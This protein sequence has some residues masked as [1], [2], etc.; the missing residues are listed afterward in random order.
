MIIEIIQTI[1]SLLQKPPLEHPNLGL[2]IM[3]KV[4]IIVRI[5]QRNRT[6]RM[7]VVFVWRERERDGQRETDLRNWG[8]ASLKSSG[9]ACRL[10]ILRRVD[11]VVQ[12]QRQFGGRIPSSLGDLS[13]F[14]LLW[15]SVEWMRPTHIIEG[16]LLYSDVNPI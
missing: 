11:V 3:L 9:Q 2:G 7:C 6:Y 1:F 8:L 12:V 5:L 4:P 16:N 15:L 13:F 10:E 14:S